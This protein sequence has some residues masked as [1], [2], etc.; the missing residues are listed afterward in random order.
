MDSRFITAAFSGTTMERNTSISSRNDT[1]MIAAMNTGSVSAS[2]R[3]RSSVMAVRPDTATLSGTTS[4]MRSRVSEVAA[5]AGA[6]AGSVGRTTV[7]PAAEIWGSPTDAMPGSSAR[8]RDS[9]GMPSASTPG[10]RRSATI[11]SG[12]LKPG[13]KPSASR[14]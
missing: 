7:S 10:L 13:P 4:R 8:R 1:T 3:V 9:S 6:V 2:W 14:S 5:S 12:A 11:S